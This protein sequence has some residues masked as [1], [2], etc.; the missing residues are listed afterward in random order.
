MALK[1]SSV[2]G[3]DVED[4]KEIHRILQRHIGQ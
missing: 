2:M 4:V 1:E 3:S